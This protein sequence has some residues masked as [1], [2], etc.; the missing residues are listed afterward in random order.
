MDE[1]TARMI[2]NR[3]EGLEKA[4]KQTARKQRAEA[5]IRV[6]EDGSTRESYNPL[7]DG[8]S[9]LED[10]VQGGMKP[11]ADNV[12]LNNTEFTLNTDAFSPDI[13]SEKVTK[14][15]TGGSSD[16]Y[17]IGLED[18]TSVEAQDIIEAL[19]LNFAEGNIFKA[20]WRQAA[21]RQG[22]G[23]AGTPTKYDREK[24]VFF[25]NRLLAR[26]I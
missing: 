10:S 24:V 18:G 20:I 3:E 13:V 5:M 25:G 6:H 15:L 21:K 11:D 22:N 2:K 23:K 9:G 7:I 12:W 17:T 1:L 4:R 16:Y 26:E 8:A 19:N 14:P